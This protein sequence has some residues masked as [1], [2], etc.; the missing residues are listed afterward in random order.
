MPGPATDP[1][2]G[3]LTDGPDA[4]NGDLNRLTPQRRAAAGDPPIPVPGDPALPYAEWARPA[5]VPAVRRDR[6]RHVASV[7][8]DLLASRGPAVVEFVV[9]GRTLPDQAAGAAAGAGGAMPTRG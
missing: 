1:L 3:V 4:N 2:V 9:D 5:G 7:R 6:P 8:S